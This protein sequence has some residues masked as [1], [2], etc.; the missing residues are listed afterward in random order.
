[1]KSVATES[2]YDKLNS[3][4]AKAQAKRSAQTMNKS[5]EK[6]IIKNKTTKKQ[7][8]ADTVKSLKS[9]V[10]TIYNEAIKK[11]NENKRAAF[12]EIETAGSQTEK[13]AFAS[14][15]NWMDSNIEM[16][17]S[18]V[19]DMFNL[20][21]AQTDENLT[22]KEKKQKNIDFVKKVKAHIE[23]QCNNMM[24]QMNDRK[25]KIFATID[26]QGK[27]INKKLDELALMMDNKENEKLSQTKNENNDL[28]KEELID[29]VNKINEQN[30]R[31]EI[32]MQNIVS[33]DQTIGFSIN[34]EEIFKENFVDILIFKRV[35]Y[36][37]FYP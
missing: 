19:E 24:K 23:N 25:K 8:N 2:E 36:F 20:R 10:E 32:Q 15:P 9:N 1:L 5:F 31:L 17:K 11:M 4:L 7:R 16:K 3:D 37:Y 6:I 33:Y 21:K 35:M 13:I 12:K 18:D 14:V 34:D 26:I 22:A 27:E 29:L 30:L 28:K